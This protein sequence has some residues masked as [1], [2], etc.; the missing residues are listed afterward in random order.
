MTIADLIKDFID[1]TKERLKTPISG[2]FLWSFIV[3]NWRPIFL[4]IFSDTSIENKIVVINYE[5]CS[6]WAIFWPLVI[7]TFYT[8]LIPKIMLLIDID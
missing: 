8:L 3:Y 4:L 6:F 1:S 7:A 2:A 5:Y